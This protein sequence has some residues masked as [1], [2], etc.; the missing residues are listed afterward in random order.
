MLFKLYNLHSYTQNDFIGKCVHVLDV[1]RRVLLLGSRSRSSRTR[2]RRRVLAV[3]EKTIPSAR[4]LHEA[5]IQIQKSRNRSLKDISFH[6][7]AFG[8]VVLKLP[9]IVV[10]N[11]TETMFLNLLAFE[12]LHVGAGREVTNYLA[13]MNNI[14]R[15]SKDISLL[16]SR[17]IIHNALGKDEAVADLFNSLTKDVTIDPGSSVDGIVKEVIIYCNRPWVRWRADIVRTYFI[18]P[19]ASIS[20]IASI[21]LFALTLLQTGYAIFAYY[22]G[23]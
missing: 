12:R 1:C 23:K 22:R 11:I 10:D 17:G 9:M 6:K 20:V 8:G 16:H 18:S 4:E 15:E 21:I 14:I 5:G 2:R 19:W 3:L 7:G 13:F